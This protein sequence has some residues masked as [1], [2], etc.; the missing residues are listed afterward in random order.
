MHNTFRVITGT[1]RSDETAAVMAGNALKGTG[2][3]ATATRD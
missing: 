3:T 1:V 2:A